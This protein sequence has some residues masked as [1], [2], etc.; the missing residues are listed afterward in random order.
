M[1]PSFFKEPVSRK[2]L[3][4]LSSQKRKLEEDKVMKRVR[5]QDVYCRFPMC[6]CRKFHLSLHV[7]HEKHRG[8]GGNPSG[9][10]TTEA[11]L[12][13]LCSA[14]HKE[15]RV[16]LDRGTLLIIPINGQDGMRGPCVW[17]VCLNGTWAEVGREVIPHQFEPFTPAQLGI[18]EALKEMTL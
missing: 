16:A 12:I 15:N 8:M 17:H 6:G 14:R 7:A 18:L 1:S 2:V 9:E 3:K 13:L 4:G 5:R 11:G 10:R